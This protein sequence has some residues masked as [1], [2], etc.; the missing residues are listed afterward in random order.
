MSHESE[1]RAPKN[2]AAS[3]LGSFLV[4][5]L[6][7]PERT[8]RSTIALAGGAAREA[9]SFLVPRAFQSSKTYEIVVT[10][11]LKFLTEQV[12]GAKS[13]NAKEPAGS[14]DSDAE[15][16]ARK[17]VGNFVDLA[18][19]LTLHMSP[20]WLLAIVSDVAY[21]SKTYVQELARE[22]KSQGLI[23][24]DST[25]ARMDDVLGAI[26]QTAG[27]TASLLD[28]PPLSVDQLKA[29]LEET[30][31]ALTSADFT[32]AL[33]Q[34]ELARYWTEMHDIAQR[35]G[36]SLLEVSSAITLHSLGKLGTITSGTL[37]GIKVAGGLLNRN[38]LNHYVD[39]L[40]TLR[41]KGFFATINECYSP[42]V[43][44]VWNNFSTDRETITEGV[45]SGRL[46]GRMYKSIRG[47]FVTNK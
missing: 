27:K 30:R 23:D 3:I 6:S 36:V 8:V 43:D 1:S 9:A 39:S 10:N 14:A 29:S 11:S 46:L 2:S 33:P 45:V 25:I 15:F 13:A 44:A 20:L 22:L 37:T 35:D 7:L 16:M 24:D 38:V 4:Y 26:Q 34:A 31:Q 47:L 32:S 12:G 42:Y 18:G 28:T 5:T 17:A 21:G 41:Q 40:S 19:G